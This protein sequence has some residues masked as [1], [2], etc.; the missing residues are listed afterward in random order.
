MDVVETK[1]LGFYCKYT[2][3]WLVD[4]TRTHLS[5]G[6]LMGTDNTALVRWLGSVNEVGVNK[7]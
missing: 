6:I 4:C 3:K 1:K 7:A 5:T 2:E